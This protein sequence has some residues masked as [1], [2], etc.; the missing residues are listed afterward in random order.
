[1][2]QAA[3]RASSVGAA[4]SL[5][6][7]VGHAMRPWIGD[8]ER[9][10]RC[11]SEWS[12]VPPQVADGLQWFTFIAA[13]P[14]GFRRTPEHKWSFYHGTEL[15]YVPS[16]IT[17]GHLRLGGKGCSISWLARDSKR[18][19]DRSGYCACWPTA[20]EYAKMKAQSRSSAWLAVIQIVTDQEP[21]RS[22]KKLRAKAEGISDD[23]RK[24]WIVDDGRPMRVFLAPV[25]QSL[26]RMR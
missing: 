12:Y 22:L 11:E 4:E 13:V 7:L 23:E 1:M 21:R 3:I 5:D 6:M 18:V 8:G 19:N 25:D 15:C 16:I 17:T 26:M 20:V 14:G 9:I 24:D 2:E 10:D